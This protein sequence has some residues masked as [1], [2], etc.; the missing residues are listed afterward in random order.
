MDRKHCQNTVPANVVKQL[1]K[2]YGEEFIN[3]RVPCESKNN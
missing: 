3:S 2:N 1:K